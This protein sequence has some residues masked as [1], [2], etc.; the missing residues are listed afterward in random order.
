MTYIA[1]IFFAFKTN[2]RVVLDV[3]MRPL[4][5]SL[6]S[7]SFFF[8]SY[9]VSQTVVFL[10]KMPSL[11]AGFNRQKVFIFVKLYKSNHKI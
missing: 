11:R 6:F 10:N 9:E 1:L 3:V 2:E 7:E 8:V 4:D 5:S